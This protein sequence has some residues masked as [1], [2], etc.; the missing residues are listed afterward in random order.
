MWISTRS[1]FTFCSSASSRSQAPSRAFDFACRAFG[2][3]GEPSSSR[4]SARRRADSSLLVREPEHTSARASRSSCPRRGS[5]ARGRNRGSS[6]RRCRGSS[7]RESRRRRCRRS[8]RGTARARRR[9]P[10]P[11][12]LSARRGAA[13]PARRG[14]SRQSATR[15][16][17]PPERV[18]TSRSPSGSRSASIARSSRA[19]RLP[20][21]VTVDL[22]LHFPCSAR[23]AS[24]SASGSAKAAEIEVEAI[25][26]VAQ[27]LDAVLDVAADVLGGIEVGLLRGRRRSLRPQARRCRSRSASTPAMITSSVDFPAPFGPSTPIF[28]REERERDVVEHLALGR[29]TWRPDHREDVVG[30][31]GRG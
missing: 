1:S 22:L 25:E 31:D 10:R 30:H 18:V 4:A 23:R 20:G 5:R 2:D 17:S 14:T 21:A 15:R 19:S 26:Q 13:D 28:A 8:R 11:G 27:R 9:T 7:G 3:D 24:K 12:D 6:R 16:R 29:R